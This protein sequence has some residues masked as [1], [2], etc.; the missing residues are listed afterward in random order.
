MDC[1]FA[2]EIGLVPFFFTCSLL[3][4]HW[5]E[6]SL[7]CF[8]GFISDLTSFTGFFLSIS[9]AWIIFFNFKDYLFWIPTKPHL[10][11]SFLFSKSHWSVI[12][13][14]IFVLTAMVTFIPNLLSPFVFSL[15]HWSVFPPFIAWVT[16]YKFRPSLTFVSPVFFSPSSPPLDP[17][18]PL[19]LSSESESDP[20]P[21]NNND[22]NNVIIN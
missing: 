16:V 9:L 12:F 20:D 22:N 18:D 2:E 21:Y 14:L 6:F 4:P 19:L 13:C 3:S 11:S 15:C 8:Y 10:S 5:S 7:H 17:S 1:F